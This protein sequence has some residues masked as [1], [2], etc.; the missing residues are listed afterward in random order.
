MTDLA[1][2]VREAAATWEHN[3]AMYPGWLVLP[4]AN[5]PAVS[6]NTDSWARTMLLSLEQLQ[7]AERLH[8]IHE[9]VWRKKILLEPFTP[10]LATAI[11]NTLALF[12]RE[13][14]AIDGEKSSD[15]KWEIIREN[16]RNTAIE[17]FVEHRWNH[18]EGAFRQLVEDLRQ[19]TDEDPEIQQAILYEQCLWA[20]YDLDFAELS[21]LLP[22]WTT[23]NCD[24]VWRIASP[25]SLPKASGCLK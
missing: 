5:R 2:A 19:L 7:P 23:E 16:W 8:A 24:P 11:E 4:A 13:I 10:E 9:L 1:Q 22:E 14:Q 12:D 3:R 21:R 25:K 6:G 20:L 18:N 17:L 15:S